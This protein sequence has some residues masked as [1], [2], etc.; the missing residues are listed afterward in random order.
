MSSNASVIEQN[1][2]NPVP[3]A[4]R[5]GRPSDLFPVWFSWNI[6]IFG[7]TL[8]IYV[9]SLGLSVWQA[10]A[11]GIIGYLLSCSFVGIL[12][13]GSVRTGLPTLAQSQMCFG[14]LGNRIPSVFGFISNMGWMIILLSMASTTLADLLIHLLPGLDDGNGRPERL[15]LF[16]SFCIIMALTLVG[17]VFGH[18]MIMKIE[19]VIALLTGSMT[20]IYLFFFVQEIDFSQINSAPAG[21][22]VTF[23]G[24]VVMA[25]TMVGLGFLNYGGDYSRYLPRHSSSSGVIFW[26]T[27]GIALPVSVL[28]VLGV[29]LSVGN[30]QMMEQAAVE[31]LAALTGILPFWFYVPFSF[32]VII[33]LVSAGMTDVY[34]AGLAFMAAGLKVPRVVSTLISAVIVALGCFYLTFISDS[35]LSTF[36]SFL[37]VISVIMGSWG[38]IEMVDLLRQ[39]ALGWEVRLA[40]PRGQG[41]FNVRWSAVISLIVA[42]VIGLGT[43]TSSDPYIARITSFLLSDEQQQSTLAQANVGLVAAMMVGAVLYALLSQVLRLEWQPKD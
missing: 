27:V 28:L 35:F 41:G 42:S 3:D 21:S 10:I 6:S 2:L 14:V 31:P 8:G 1:G 20:L 24:G 18:A 38:A 25:M 9:L 43:I 32:I 40:L 36:T 15:T 37:A 4:E 19:R 7:I 5:Y 30:P 26:T 17:A 22:A 11:A 33:S 23:I 34:S 39:K 29:L 12:S 13:T 16:V